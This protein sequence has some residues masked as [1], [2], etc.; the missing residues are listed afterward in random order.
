MRTTRMPVCLCFALQ[1]ATSAAAQGRP[2]RLHDF[3]FDIWC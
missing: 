2:Y 1:A 3:N